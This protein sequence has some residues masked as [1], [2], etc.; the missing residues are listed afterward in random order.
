MATSAHARPLAAAALDF[1]NRQAP[2][3]GFDVS[4]EAIFSGKYPPDAGDGL[5]R[6]AGVLEDWVRYVED[7]LANQIDPR[8]FARLEASTDLMEQVQQLLDDGGVHVAAPIMLAGAGLEEFLRYLVI[9]HGAEVTRQP[10]LQAYSEALRTA[11]VLSPQNVKN[12]T[13]WAGFR[14]QAAHGQFEDLT[15]ENAVLMAQ[16]VNLFLQQKG[17]VT[18]S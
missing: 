4:A 15:R 13:V 11:G 12:V 17:P 16:G 7:G 2:G 1:L 5:Q 14:N 3:G 8:A 10:G 9:T 6:L 18:T